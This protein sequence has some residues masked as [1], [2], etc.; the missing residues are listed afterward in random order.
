MYQ[1]KVIGRSPKGPVVEVFWIKCFTSLEIKMNT[2]KNENEQFALTEIIIV[3][4]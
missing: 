4:R 3:E 1:V 2:I